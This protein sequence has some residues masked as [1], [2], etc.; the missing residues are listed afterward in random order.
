MVDEGLRLAR[1]TSEHYFTAE[2]YRLKGELLLRSAVDVEA[3][4]VALAEECFAQALTIARYQQARSWELRTVMSVAGL[5]TRQGRRK[6]ARMLV[7][8]TYTWFKEGHDTADLKAA[9]RALHELA[10]VGPNQRF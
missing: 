7:Q 1:E 10:A 2:L 3:P 8:E 9:N 6:A 5:Y 4:S